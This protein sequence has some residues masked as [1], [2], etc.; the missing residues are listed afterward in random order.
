MF[1][2]L[3]IKQRIGAGFTMILT[4]LLVIGAWSIFGIKG[5][6]DNASQVIDGNILR[7]DMV[8]REV[9]HLNW[10]NHVN[11]LLTDDSI[12]T[13]DV[14]TDPHKC[15]FGKWYY[16]QERE[17][18]E[19]LVPELGSLFTEIEPYHNALHESATEIDHAYN[20]VD[21]GLGQF[22]AE[23]VSDHLKWVSSCQ[24]LFTN[25]LATL[26]AC[27]DDHACSLGKFLHG[28]DGERAAALDPEL[29]RMIG[30]VKEPHAD[31]HQGA[32]D[33]KE[34]WRQQHPGLTGLL[35][36]RLDD[37]R[38]WTASVAGAILGGAKGLDVQTDPTKC[39]FGHFLNSDQARE[40]SADFPALA[41][42]LSACQEPHAKL[43]E[44]AITIDKA[45]AAGDRQKAVAVYANEV[46]EY[47]AIMAGH[48]NA[49]IEAE[50]Q[51]VHAG[52]QSR[53]I[54]KN[55]ILTSLG[56]V[57]FYLDSMRAR[58][59]EL[60]A[61]YNQAN[62]INASNTKPNLEKI[63][64]LLGEINDVASKNIM[65][66][67][68]MLTSA[69]SM[70]SGIS[71]TALVALTLGIVVATLLSR[72]IVKA[73]ITLMVNLRSGSENVTSASTEIYD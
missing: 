36:S 9:D 6:V 50:N 70:R 2:K 29:A 13:L 20:Q 42:E 68:E 56:E 58:N 15:A 18:A 63:Q 17:D 24:E 16:G 34:I 67:Q 48:F 4:L 12:N 8:Q 32:A 66:D 64:A 43:H 49:A 39:A 14:Q 47:V 35:F 54:F 52:D 65:T 28:E 21:L 23:K 5:V 7:G 61:G 73:L 37:H 45:L 30:E 40:Y 55:Q 69:R 3:T 22:L 71:L 33:I 31:L 60:V 41:K 25:N 44:A 59:S 27:S 1:K 57:E 62:S 26:H 46:S 19:E 72:G 53:E 11:A 38:R 51:N 10:A